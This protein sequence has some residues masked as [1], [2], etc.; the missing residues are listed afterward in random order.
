MTDATWSTTP[1]SGDFNTGSNWIGGVVPDGIALFGTS[2]TTSLSFSTD[3][4]M[5]GWESNLVASDYI[6]AMPAGTDTSL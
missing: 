6:F 5:D 2:T 3:I 1:G 4:S